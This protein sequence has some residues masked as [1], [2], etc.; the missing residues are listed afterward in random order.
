MRTT[1]SILKTLWSRKIFPHCIGAIY[2]V[3]HLPKF[4][5]SQKQQCM[6]KWVFECSSSWGSSVLFY[7]EVERML[8]PCPKYQD[9]FSPQAQLKICHLDL[10]LCFKHCQDILQAISVFKYIGFM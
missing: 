10:W 3:K 7:I 6:E 9:E 8:T 5:S 1:Y 4:T 2:E